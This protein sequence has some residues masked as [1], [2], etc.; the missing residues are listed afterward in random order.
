VW[1]GGAGGGGVLLERLMYAY[2]SICMYVY[3][4][5]CIYVY[6]W[7]ATRGQMN[8]CV[9]VYVLCHTAWINFFIKYV[10]I[11]VYICMHMKGKGHVVLSG[12]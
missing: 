7:E 9:C 11:D 3:L 5:I 12:L 8:V 4:C 10:N 2:V 1:V 6:M